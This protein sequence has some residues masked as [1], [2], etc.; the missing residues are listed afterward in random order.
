[1]GHRVY[2]G[3]MKLKVLMLVLSICLLITFVGVERYIGSQKYNS[4][5]LTMI[6]DLYKNIEYEMENS[7]VEEIESKYGCRILM[8]ED[9]NYSNTL[10]RAIRNSDIILDYMDGDALLGK[11]IF[12]S[13]SNTFL[14]LKRNL[15]IVIA[16]VFAVTF[17]VL[18][19]VLLLIYIRIIRPF[20]RLEHFAGR[21]SAGNLDIPL[22]MDKANY[23][24]AFT[25]SFDL[26]RE[27]LKRAR[28]GEYEANI[29]KKELVAELSHDIKTPVS[30]IKALCELLEVTSTDEDMIKKLGTIHQKADVIDKL[31]SNMFHATLEE[32]EVLKIEPQEEYSTIILSMF[33]DLNHYNK[34]HIKNSLPGCLIYCDKLRLN[35]VIDNIVNNSYKYANTDIDVSFY[36]DGSFVNIE[37][38]DYGDGV[39]K[40]DL[41]LVCEKFF[42]GSNASSHDGSGLGLYL[43]KLFMEGMEGKLECKTENGFVV[44]LGIRKI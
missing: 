32:L 42:R 35:Q 13:N 17:I 12:P 31:I 5:D 14:Q 22:T 23:F 38:R 3:I 19:T 18:Y 41:L 6:N 33:E 7:A 9:P 36:E 29:S 28:Q 4:C 8:R 27:E 10:Y 16:I 15:A 1:M 44:R 37:V 26:M 39:K 2:D 21:I 20:Q 43:A 40:E 34:I 11:I 25:E 30:T 24:G